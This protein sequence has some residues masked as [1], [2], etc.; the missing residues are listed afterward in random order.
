MSA[1]A[2]TAPSMI[3]SDSLLSLVISMLCMRAA[4]RSRMAGPS[5]SEKASAVAASQFLRQ[6]AN[7]S[8]PA[9]RKILRVAV[10]S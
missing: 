10:S 5:I 6:R 8:A 4:T 7:A 3:S 2:F 1:S 9:L